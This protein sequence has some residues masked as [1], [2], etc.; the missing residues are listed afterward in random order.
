MN[1]ATAAADQEDR[2]FL[3]PDRLDGFPHPRETLRLYGQDEAERILLQA[4]V[5]QRMHHAWLLAGPE[6]IGK[7]TLA[8]RFARFVLAHPEGAPP[9]A[10]QDL[11]VPDAS[12][13]AAQV[14]ALSHPGLL[15]LQRPWQDQGKRFATAITV[16]EVRRLRAFLGRTADQGHWR[17]VIVDRADELNVNAANALLKSLEEPPK[18]TVFLLVAS[19]PG[20]LPVTVRSRCRMLRL[21][22]LAT[23]VLIDAV[24]A[25][26]GEAGVG[27]ADDAKL[28]SC[29]ALAQGS[30][31]HALELHANDGIEIYQRLLGVLRKLPRVDH[32][33]I[34]ALADDVTARGAD[35]KFEMLHTL[36]GDALARLVR[37]AATGA[38][39]IGE[40]ADLAG[41]L[42]RPQR[43]APWA[44]LW[45]TVTRAKAD[46][47]A[48]N[49][50]RKNLILGTF[51]RL[52]ETA[53]STASET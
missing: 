33:A 42:I 2:R 6:G 30:V 10:R 32:S 52:E 23:D 47:F 44:E 39:A 31:R 13:V 26:A 4:H 25:V 14:A 48:L 27:E 34:H 19:A 3:D 46:A 8:Y 15:V 35:D 18:R 37:Q 7:A 29:A 43:L 28:A 38:G 45:E 12:P 50:D 9:E 11:S 24:R 49:L 5:T 40:E 51:F 22:P 41:R 17:V 1:A 53:R 36:F 20:R 16:S 21:R